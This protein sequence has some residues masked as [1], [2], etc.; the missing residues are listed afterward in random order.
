MKSTRLIT[1]TLL[2]IGLNTTALSNHPSFDCRKAKTTTEKE[3]CANPTLAKL[4]SD[5]ASAYIT[6][7]NHPTD[8][9]TISVDA[10]IADQKK[11]LK[12][13]D[14]DSCHGECLIKKYQDRITLLSFPGAPKQ[15]STQAVNALISYY[16]DKTCEDITNCNVGDRFV[17]DGMG[18]FACK[19]YQVNPELASRLFGSCYGSNRD[20]FTPSCDFYQ[21]ANQVSGLAPYI[22]FLSTLYGPDVNACGTLRYGQYR[23]QNSAVGEALYN[24]NVSS[25]NTNDSLMQHYSLTSLWNKQQYQHYQQLKQQAELGLQQYYNKQFHLDTN[26]A[27]T[28]AAYH[29]NNLAQEYVGHV[30]HRNSWGLQTL[31]DYLK[32]GALPTNDDFQYE[33]ILNLNS[34]PADLQQAKPEVLAYFLTMAVVNQYSIDDIKKLIND[35]ANL[36]NPKLTDTALMNAVNR[37]DVVKLLIER[38]ANINGQNTFGKTALMYAIQYGNFTAVKLLVEGKA[39]VN[40]AT[41]GP[42]DDCEYEIQVGNRTPLMYA[43]WQGNIEIVNY[44]ISKG[45]KTDS[46]DTDGHDYHFYKPSIERVKS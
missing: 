29:V 28:L 46:K 31:N 12:E 1:F 4:D 36:K 27:K 43:A 39:D 7:K 45:A 33:T 32:N 25:T 19:S 24:I 20:N 10:L 37:P 2:I 8:R 21:Q 38:G 9:L 30:S 17:T 6:L 15:L 44:L 35:G 26:K 22:H 41:F 16:S 23:A 11:W 13:R 3:I 14:Q 5:L 40:M 42:M 34:A 18:E